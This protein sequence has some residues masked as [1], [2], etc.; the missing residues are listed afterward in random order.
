MIEPAILRVFDRSQDAPLAPRVQTLRSIVAKFGPVAPAPPPPARPSTPEERDP[1]PRAPVAVTARQV[2]RP[3]RAIKS[4]CQCHDRYNQGY[5]SYKQRHATD[6]DPSSCQARL[7]PV[8]IFKPFIY[9][10]EAGFPIVE[11]N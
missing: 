7:A 2:I 1:E 8:L 9:F 10:T 11:L 5:D 6:Y 4:F 3:Q